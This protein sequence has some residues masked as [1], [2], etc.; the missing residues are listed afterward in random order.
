MRFQFCGELDCPDWVLAGINLLSRMSSLK[1]RTMCSLVM[2]SL[3]GEELD[4]GKVQK[5]STDAKLTEQEQRAAVAV[6]QYILESAVRHSVATD[7]LEQELQQLGLPREHTASLGRVLDQQ[8]HPLR[9]TLLERTVKEPGF[10]EVQWEVATVRDSSDP[11]S[12]A[13]QLSLTVQLS[14]CQQQQQ[15]RQRLQL[16]FSPETAA[17]C[18]RELLLA[19]RRMEDVS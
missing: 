10:S 12:W 3:L 17:V 5:V 16:L 14:S 11:D 13:A 7:Q 6:L 19:R 2:K 18:H 8:R 9:R 4:M 15:Q 1:L